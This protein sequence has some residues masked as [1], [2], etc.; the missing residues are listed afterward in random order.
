MY[1]SILY[2]D[3]NLCDQKHL[4]WQFL[5]KTTL[6]IW[7][8]VPY[9]S[10]GRPKQMPNFRKL[11]KMRD[12]T[13]PLWLH[14]AHTWARSFKLLR[15]PRIDYKKPIPLGCVAWRAD[16]PIP[17]RFLAPH[18]LFKNSSTGVCSLIYHGQHALCA[19]SPI[20][21]FGL[22]SIF[23]IAMSPWNLN[24]NYTST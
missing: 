7:K 8:C 18:R 16:N 2:A 11:A 17:T 6:N 4:F 3:C 13:L 1:S 10:T 20:C 24:W 14:R 15:S 22:G 19:D 5:C 12:N 23:Y 21:K 9:M